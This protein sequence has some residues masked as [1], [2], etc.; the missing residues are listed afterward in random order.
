MTTFKEHLKASAARVRLWPKWKRNILGPPV[1]FE[2]VEVKEMNFKQGKMTLS[3]AHPHLAHFAEAVAEFFN[4]AMGVNY[5]ATSF[6]REDL[7][8]MEIVVQRND[9]KTPAQLHQELLMA[10]ETK[11]PGESRHETALRYIIESENRDSGC[12]NNQD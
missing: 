6:W 10:V 3:L 11:V 8:P 12:A 9:G 1:G 4:D 7:G 2:P 5:V